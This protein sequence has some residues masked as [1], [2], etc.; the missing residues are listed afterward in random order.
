MGVP[1][2]IEKEM[3]I[4]KEE[5]LRVMA[6]ALDGCPHRFEGEEVRVED[7]D[8]RLRISFYPQTERRIG[9]FAIPVSRVRLEFEGY[10][11]REVAETVDW[12]D[13]RFQRGGG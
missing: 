5:F 3:G 2:I 8:R 1:V 4:T 10:D 7:G 6:R 13:R 12:F 9:L 11:E